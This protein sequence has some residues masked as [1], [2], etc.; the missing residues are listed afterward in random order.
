MKYFGVGT[1]C[2]QYP[3]EITDWLVVG[4][5]MVG[6]YEYSATTLYS[7]STERTKQWNGKTAKYEDKLYD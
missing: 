5:T 7:P 2:P 4:W 3:P 6:N 1:A